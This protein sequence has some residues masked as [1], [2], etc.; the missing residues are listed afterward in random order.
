M[1]ASNYDCEDVLEVEKIILIL[2]FFVCFVFGK[3]HILKQT[4]QMSLAPKRPYQNVMYP[5]KARL[6]LQVWAS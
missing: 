1:K 4:C 2:V 3:T 5:E 6:R